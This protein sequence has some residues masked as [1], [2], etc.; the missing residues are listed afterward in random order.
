M[1]AQ[2]ALLR[3]LGLR[4]E[5]DAQT[6][7]REH[8][9]KLAAES[10]DKQLHK[11]LYLSFSQAVRHT[12]KNLMETNAAEQAEAYAIHPG[13]NL[14][15]WTLDQAARIA[16]L[17]S[18]PAGPKTIEALLALQQSA[19]LGEHLALVRALF[20]LTDAK[21]LLHVA[22]EAI[23]SNMRDVFAA[24]SQNNPYPEQY[25]DDIAWNQMVVKCLFV[26]LPLRSI[27]GLDRRANS[28]LCRILV[29]LSQERLAAGRPLSPEAWR[30]VGPF[31]DSE[32]SG[33]AG[34]Q[35]LQAIETALNGTL[36][37][38]RGAALSLWATPGK[39]GRER[40]IAKAPEL[41]PS[42]ENGTL[43]WENYDA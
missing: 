18:L 6:W 21:G 36:S 1:K 24:I 19:D 29:D 30:C 22:R 14:S 16:L 7:L 20:L 35:A 37:E 28:E 42:L 26:D 13:W 32:V 34:E 10:S 43:N 9:Q 12:G 8:C 25:C 31:A 27:Y 38:R 23:R 3:W 33:S 41:I 4:L 11:T 40:L 39:R 17:L 5:P 15:G 2:D